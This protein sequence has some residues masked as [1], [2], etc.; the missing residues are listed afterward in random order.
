MKNTYW[1]RFAEFFSGLEVGELFTRKELKNNLNIPNNTLDQYRRILTVNNVVAHI[2]EGIYMKCH[3][4]PEG[5]SMTELRL[6]GYGRK[7]QYEPI[8]WYDKITHQMDITY[9][10]IDAVNP[11]PLFKTT[12]RS[13]LDL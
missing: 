8:I 13:V 3:N 9:K 11:N 7:E 6:K 12:R 4:L 10:K 5:I 2:K 1:G